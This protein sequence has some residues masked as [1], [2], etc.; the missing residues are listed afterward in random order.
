MKTLDPLAV[1]VEGTHLVE[2]SAGTGKTFTIAILT[3]RLVVERRI[4]I[5]RV[6]V[7]TYTNAA[8]AELRGR[9]RSRLRGAFLALKGATVD[10]G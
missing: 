1:S 8:T 9:I 3:L 7:V 5:S 2:A 10:A 4:P 6:L